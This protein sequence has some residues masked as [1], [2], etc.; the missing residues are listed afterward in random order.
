MGRVVIKLEVIK[1][2]SQQKNKYKV[3][4]EEAS[5]STITPF[6]TNIP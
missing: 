2:F 1:I 4:D 5:K 3:V 6:N